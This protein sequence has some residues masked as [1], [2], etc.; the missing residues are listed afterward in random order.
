MY[1]HTYKGST[2]RLR[3]KNSRVSLRGSCRSPASDPA[4]LSEDISCHLI[5]I[6]LN[7]IH[8]ELTSHDFKLLLL[9]SRW[10]LPSWTH[11]CLQIRRYNS[12]ADLAIFCALRIS[13]HPSATA[14]RPHNPAPSLLPTLSMVAVRKAPG[15]LSQ[16]TLKADFFRWDLGS[17]SWPRLFN[18]ACRFRR[19]RCPQISG[20]IILCH[21]SY[22]NRWLWS[23]ISLWR[24][25]NTQSSSQHWHFKPNEPQGWH[26]GWLGYCNKIMGIC[27]Y[28]TLNGGKTR[29]SIQKRPEW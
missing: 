29:R 23:Q 17:R 24:Q 19:R 6:M 11:S 14:W 5:T 9:L 27:H 8:Y 26:G 12:R 20:I 25:F 21:H 22:R 18:Y 7:K 3:G 28:I 13:D 10:R 4:G 15:F 2:G 1:A 16:N